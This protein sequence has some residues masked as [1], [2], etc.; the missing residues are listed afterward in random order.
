MKHLENKPL[1]RGFTL[2]ESLLVL[3][4][5][6]IFIGVP[7]LQINQWEE[8]LVY[9][10]FIEEFEQRLIQTQQSAIVFRKQ[11]RVQTEK[12]S[13]TIEFAFYRGDGTFV[14]EKLKIPKGVTIQRSVFLRFMGMTGNVEQHHT[15]R[16][17]TPYH[18]KYLEYVYQIGSGRFVVKET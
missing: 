4:V 9:Q 12:K 8:R 7:L 18:S 17:Q 2:I 14:I 1:L 5:V 16:F 6:T 3:L 13:E 15:F 10:G 11:T